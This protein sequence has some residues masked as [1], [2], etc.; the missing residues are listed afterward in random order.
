M[1]AALALDL[2]P[3]AASFCR[4][5]LEQDPANEELKKLLEQVDA[6][7]SEQERQRA[8]VAKALAAAKVSSCQ[9][10]NTFSIRM[11]WNDWCYW[12]VYRIL[13]LPWRREG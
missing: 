7:L 12:V 10:N 2:L 8:K 3:D 5:G 11:R 1:K 9:M 6:K 4:R 13:L